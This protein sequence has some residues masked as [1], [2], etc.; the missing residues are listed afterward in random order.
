MSKQNTFVHGSATGHSSVETMCVR[1]SVIGGHVVAVAKLF[2]TKSAVIAARLYYNLHNLAVQRLRPAASVNLK[3]E[4]KC[5]ASATSEGNTKKT[6]K[7][8]DECARLE[9]NRKLALALDIDPETHQN[10]HVPYSTSTLRMYAEKVAWAT[11]LER[12]FR[13]FAAD[14]EARRLRFKAMKD[15]QRAFLH[16]LAEDF[17]FDSESLDPEP[18]RHVCIFK[19]PRFVAAP[20]K[21]LVESLRVIHQ[22][23][24][25]A[26]LSAATSTTPALTLA[27]QPP[28]QPFN[29]LLLFSPRFGL[30]DSE[31]TEALAPALKAASTLTLE[32]TFSSQGG[33][34][35]VLLRPKPTSS[36]TTIAPPVIASLLKTLKNPVH[37]ALVSKGLATS[38]AL[39][40][41]DHAGSILRSETDPTSSY[42][43]SNAAGPWST[44]ESTS[45]GSGGG[46]WSQ[47]AAKGAA[48]LRFAPRPESVRGRNNFVVLERAAAKKK[49]E[50]EMVVDDWEEEARKEEKEL[51]ERLERL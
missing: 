12:E 37:T 18:H 10:D 17:G 39:V 28:Q 2:S 47:V 46:G 3:T 45:S 24:L 20:M 36:T 43:T 19:T 40:A 1:N 27:P 29:A 16:S 50:K 42:S 44:V 5:L 4:T 49:R 8:D 9:R 15:H 30:T 41:I 51:E 11:P 34:D 6:L 14:D 13:V 21:T 7:C 31:L 48:G 35:I 33:Q 38:V 25:A 32:P 22:G 26:G 23:N